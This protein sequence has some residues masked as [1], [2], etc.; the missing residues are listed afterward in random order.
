MLTT[1]ISTSA[2]IPKSVYNKTKNIIPDYYIKGRKKFSLK[3]AKLKTKTA[4]FVELRPPTVMGKPIEVDFSMR[5]MDINSIN[6]EDM[7]FR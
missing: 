4:N 1:V 6:V 7:D 2:L 5:V 3:Q